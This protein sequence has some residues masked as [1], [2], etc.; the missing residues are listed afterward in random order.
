MLFVFTA[1]QTR[2]NLRDWT[3]K[4]HVLSRFPTVSEVFHE[5]M[6]GDIGFFKPEKSLVKLRRSSLHPKGV[7]GI[8]LGP[9]LDSSYSIGVLYMG[10]ESEGKS[11]LQYSVID[12]RSF[13]STGEKAFVEEMK[14]LIK[15][16][17]ALAN[18]GI[19]LYAHAAFEKKGRL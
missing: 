5:R 2:L 10:A 17:E 6:L 19:L 12:S 16:L 9:R 4:S 15:G 1:A 8:L 3:G 11:T 7:P 18:D 13:F 14:A